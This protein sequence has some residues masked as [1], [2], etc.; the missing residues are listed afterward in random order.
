MSPCHGCHAG[1]C[2]SFVVPVTG[3]D[4]LHLERA[5]GLPLEEIVCRWADAEG[6]IARGAAP[7]FRFEDDLE[8]P[9]VIGLRHVPSE[10]H[11]GT[12]RCEFLMETPPTPE[13]PL[14][15][16]RCGVYE[17]RPMACRIYPARFNST[18]ELTILSDVP[19]SGREHEHPAY[20][21]CPRPWQPEDVDPLELPRTM[22]AAKFERE[23]FR[24]VARLWNDVPRAFADLPDFFRWVYDNRVWSEAPATTLPHPAA[25][26][27]AA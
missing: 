9:Y 10:A 26:R 23:F 8:T 3:A 18:S 4:L 24:S 19:R 12:S 11:P 16:A 27:R 15:G 25:I 17:N 13:A 5:R 6:R 20:Q 7:H 1:C 2:R 22:A 14:G 21:L